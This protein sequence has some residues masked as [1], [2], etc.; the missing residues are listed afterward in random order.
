MVLVAVACGGE[1]EGPSP[2]DT[3]ATGGD[4]GTGVGSSADAGAG[5]GGASDASGGTAAGS[6]GDS[7]D[8]GDAGAGGTGG[9]GGLAGGTSK[10]GEVGSK[11]GSPSLPPED[12]PPMEGCEPRAASAGPDYCKVDHIC[13]NNQFL[14]TFCLADGTGVLACSCQGASRYQD[15]LIEGASG[16]AACELVA[17]VCA[18]GEEVSFEDPPECSTRERSMGLDYCGLTE[19]CRRK[20]DLG[21]GVTAVLN[22]SKSTNCYRESTTSV[23]CECVGNTGNY[24]G[25]RL[26]TSDLGDACDV[27]HGICGSEDP[28][29]EGETEC[30]ATHQSSGTDYCEVNE[31][32]TDTF[33]IADG[34]VAVSQYSRWASCTRSG[35]GL[36]C[37][38]Q[39]DDG[40]LELG[41]AGTP[42]P[43]TCRDTLEI[44]R[45]LD[46]L[47]VTGEAEC[48]Q[49]SQFGDVDFCNASLE[50]AMDATIGDEP[51]RVFGNLDVHCNR[52]SGNWSC[53]CNTYADSATLTVDA[54]DAWEACT[55]ATKRCP[56][57][58][59]VQPSAG[60]GL[61]PPGG[62]PIPR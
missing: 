22:E 18:E 45:A 52:F 60:G 41:R 34:V 39:G 43:E 12:P 50:C 61:I 19:V 53:G 8:P 11:G 6:A 48:R 13:E 36:R 17:E 30:T 55:E 28:E 44:C 49:R 15:Y 27:L 2:G 25:Y 32:C 40:A 46:A 14:S 29:V 3:E 38:C 59:D 24:R 23:Y 21:N 56:E 20:A 62:G 1:S 10:G 51:V 26:Q 33:E 16:L 57:A 58:V 47:E 42:S 37:H 9:S 54:S 7:G 4:G 35:D 5:D 31:T